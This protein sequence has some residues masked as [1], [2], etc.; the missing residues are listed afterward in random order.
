VSWAEDFLTPMSGPKSI[1]SLMAGLRAPS[2]IA[3][4][5]IVP[6][7]MSTLEKSS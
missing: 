3:A 7:R 6:T 4:S 2:R 1:D 5:T